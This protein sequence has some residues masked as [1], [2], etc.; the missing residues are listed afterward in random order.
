MFAVSVTI[1]I[2][3]TASAVVAPN[4]TN[5]ERLVLNCI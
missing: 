1:M 5:F 4:Y 2:T 3:A